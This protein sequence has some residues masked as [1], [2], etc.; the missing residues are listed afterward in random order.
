MITKVI[1]WLWLGIGLPCWLGSVVT[2]I[3]GWIH[4]NDVKEF[5]VIMTGGILGILKALVIWSE[6][7]DAIEAKVKAFFKKKRRHRIK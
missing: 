6:K 4:L 7:G 2:A 5:I 1:V 3:F